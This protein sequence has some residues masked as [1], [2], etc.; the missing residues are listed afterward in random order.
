[1]TNIKQLINKGLE[2]YCIKRGSAVSHPS[3]CA[4]K[5]TIRNS[6]RIAITYYEN[7]FKLYEYVK[8][9]AVNN[10]LLME[11]SN[12]QKENFYKITR[13]NITYLCTQIGGSAAKKLAE[14]VGDYKEVRTYNSTKNP[15]VYI[16]SF[17]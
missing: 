10:T 14:F 17:K 13:K 16:E 11:L 1:M 5:I 3:D 8:F 2:Q 6:G 4:I 15:I 9:Y 7:I 12:E